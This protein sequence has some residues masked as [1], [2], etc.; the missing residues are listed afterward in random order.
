M[1][2]RYRCVAALLLMIATSTAQSADTQVLRQVSTKALPPGAAR[3]F[4]DRYL[5]LSAGIFDPLEEELFN[6]ALTSPDPR[7]VSAYGIVQ[8]ESR[9]RCGCRSP[10]SVGPVGIVLSAAQRVPGA[11]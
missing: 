10:A 9:C 8:F 3:Q 5:M 11:V 4:D 2:S 1:N 7:P 6:K